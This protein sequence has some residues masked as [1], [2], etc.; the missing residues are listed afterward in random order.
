MTHLQQQPQLPISHQDITPRLFVSH[1]LTSGKPCVRRFTKLCMCAHVYIYA[2]VCTYVCTCVCTYVCMYVG[3]G[4][5]M[6]F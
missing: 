1:T 6:C 3:K 2:C 5:C 4:V